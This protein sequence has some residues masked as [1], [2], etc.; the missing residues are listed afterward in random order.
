[1]LVFFLPP[2][3]IMTIKVVEKYFEENASRKAEI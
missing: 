2:Q 1:M 3:H